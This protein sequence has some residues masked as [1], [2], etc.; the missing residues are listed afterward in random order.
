VIFNCSKTANPVECTSDTSHTSWTLI[1]KLADGVTDSPADLAFAWPVTVGISNADGVAL[2]ALSSTPTITVA[3]LADDYAFESG[4]SMACPHAVGVAALVWGAAPNATAT[5]VRQA[6]T[7]TAT[8][9][10]STG[11]D[12][13]FG[14]G[15]LNAL[16]AAKSI[17]PSK[18]G[19]GATPTPVPVP[20]R[21]ITRRGR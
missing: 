13:T 20:G 9:L 14:F 4:T 7:S 18:F 8:D 19:S 10:G 12:N 11:K 15:L 2:R 16:Q 3:N 6:M 21:R 1:S 5:D 17:A